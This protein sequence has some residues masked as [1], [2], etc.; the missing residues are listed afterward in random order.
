MKGTHH[1]SVRSVSI[2][3][4][5]S[6]QEGEAYTVDSPSMRID[7]KNTGYTNPTI[8]PVGGNIL[9]V[10]GL[11]VIGRLLVPVVLLTWRTFPRVCI[12]MFSGT[13]SIDHFM[14]CHACKP[15]VVGTEALNNPEYHRT[16][17][18]YMGVTEWTNRSRNHIRWCLYQCS[19]FTPKIKRLIYKRH[20]EKRREASSPTG[21]RHV[22]VEPRAR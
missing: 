11:H 13:N 15:E 19:V 1:N 16:R 4:I 3:V 20:V 14:I 21:G 22:G 2:T 9:V 18:M 6:F 8:T 5:Q 17:S 10:F 12:F 7:P